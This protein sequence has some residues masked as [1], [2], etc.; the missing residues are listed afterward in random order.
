MRKRF[1]LLTNGETVDTT[2]L[3]LKLNSFGLKKIGKFIKEHNA[4]VF[5]NTQPKMALYSVR[6]RKEGE[7][8]IYN[9]KVYYFNLKDLNNPLNQIF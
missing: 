4:N 3:L 8:V 6:L 7:K 1:Y 2:M 9:G 5:R